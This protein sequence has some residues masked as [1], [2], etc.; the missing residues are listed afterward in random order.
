MTAVSFLD[1]GLSGNR[2]L[3]GDGLDWLKAR[4][5]AGAERFGKLGLPTQKLESWKYTRLRP[6]D[7]TA[8]TPIADAA[9][10]TEVKDLRLE[11]HDL[12]EVV[13]EQAQEIQLIKSSMIADRDDDQ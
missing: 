10:A 4:R 2:A 6:L 1:G 8:Y 7:D 3:P 5:E 13:A 12:R 9:D 11:A